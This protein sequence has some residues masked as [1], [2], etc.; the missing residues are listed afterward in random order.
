MDLWELIEKKNFH[1]NIVDALDYAEQLVEINRSL[2][3]HRA[4]RF[5]GAFY[6]L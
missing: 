5:C 4:A 1:E 3:Y 6:R 2:T